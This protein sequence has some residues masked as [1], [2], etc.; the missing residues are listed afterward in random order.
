MPKK[1]KVSSQPPSKRSVAIS[2]CIKCMPK[3]QNKYCNTIS[4]KE[5]DY[6]YTK[7]D[8]KSSPK[9]ESNKL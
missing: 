7:S 5:I 2:K 9:K 1:Q 6:W 4:A 3:G 8:K